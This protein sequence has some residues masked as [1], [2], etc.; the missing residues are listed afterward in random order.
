M[1][2]FSRRESE[3]LQRLQKLSLLATGLG[4]V[5]S[6]ILHYETFR[7]KTQESLAADSMFIQVRN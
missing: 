1:K 5:S 3:C 2:E 6:A 4:S 7:T